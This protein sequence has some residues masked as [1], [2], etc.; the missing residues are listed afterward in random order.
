MPRTV[1][2]DRNVQLI[3]GL[4]RTSSYLRCLIVGGYTFMLATLFV[5]AMIFVVKPL[6]HYVYSIFKRHGDVADSSL[7]ASML[8]LML[9]TSAFT[10]EVIGMF[11]EIVCWLILDLWCP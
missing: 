3:A 1:S 6:V 5:L 4:S 8:F 10:A 2:H 9:L 11:L 7:F